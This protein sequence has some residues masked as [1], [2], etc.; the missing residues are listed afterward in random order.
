MTQQDA[1]RCRRIAAIAAQLSRLSQ[2]AGCTIIQCDL[3]RALRYGVGFRIGMAALGEG[4]VAVEKVFRIGDTVIAA[5][6][7]IGP[8]ALGSVGLWDHVS[9]I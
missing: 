9:A 5:H 3:Q 6:W 7:I 1:V 8:P 2:R 4:T